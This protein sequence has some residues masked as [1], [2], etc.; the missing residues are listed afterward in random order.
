MFSFLN[1][2]KWTVVIAV[3]AAA[4]GKIYL[5]EKRIQAQKAKLERQS[6]QIVLKDKFLENQQREIK[7]HAAERAL[8]EKELAT[9][10]H[11]LEVIQKDIEESQKARDELAGKFLE[12]DLEKL[13][14]AKPGLIQRRI[15][16]G[17]RD[18][19]WMLSCAT[20]SRDHACHRETRKTQKRATPLPE[21]R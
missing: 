19:F 15:N 14:K 10:A 20:K 21:K 17:T 7:T 12:H 9:L 13:T 8:W 2:A 1:S 5:D 6:N 18:A 4:G 3:L 16:D 11:D